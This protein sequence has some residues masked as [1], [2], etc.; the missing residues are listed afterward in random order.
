MR[1]LLCF[2]L[3]LSFLY[4]PAQ[5]TKLYH[6]VLTKQDGLNFDII[7]SMAFD[8][9]GFLWLGGLNFDTRSIISNTKKRT[10]QRFD[11]QHFESFEVPET[12]SDQQVRK[13]NQIVP[14]ND[15][16]FYVLGDNLFSVFNPLTQEFKVVSSFP[17]HFSS[18]YHYNE[19]DY[20]LT[21][22]GREIT[23]NILNDVSLQ[24]LFSFTSSE[25][26]FLVEESSKIIFHENGVLI[27]DDNFPLLFFNWDGIL[28]KRYPFQKYESKN[29]E[30][31][32]DFMI[33]EV[34]YKDNKI[35]AFILNNQQLYEIDFNIL[36]V[37]P[38]QIPNT[39]LEETTIYSYKNGQENV[40]LHTS[41][42]DLMFNRLTENGF[43]TTTAR[44]VFSRP[45]AL[46]CTSTDV[47]KDLWVGTNGGELHYFKFPSKKIEVYMPETEMRT[48]VPL[49]GSTYLVCSEKEGWYV[50]DEITK[51]IVPYEVS[52]NGKK[53]KPNSTR[54]VLVE[55]DILWFNENGF[56]KMNRETRKSNYIKHFPVMCFEPLNEDVIIYGT[57]GY[58]LMSFNKRTLQHDSIA[59][60]D[61]LAIYDL[62]IH[63]NIVVGA[64]SKGILTY[65]VQDKKATMYADENVL[66]DPFLLMADYQEPYGFVLGSRDGT[67]VSYN[68]TTSKYSTLY[69]DDLGAGIAKIVY[70]GPN[71]WISTFNGL[72]H[73]NIETKS[74]QRF[75]EKDGLSD[76]EGNRY[77]GL[78]TKE[79][80]LIGSIKGLNYF[81]PKDLKS[82]AID[83]QLRL[84]ECKKYDL[85][86]NKITS[87]FNQELLGQN[88]VI[89]LPAEHKELELSFALTNNVGFNENSYSYRLNKNEWVALGKEQSIR[90]VNMASGHYNLEIAAHD[91]TGN[92]IGESLKI[93][94]NSKA[95]F[96][97]TWWFYLLISIAVISLLLY[98]L[99]EAQKR[100]KMQ[101]KFSRDLM[102]SQEEERNRIAKELHDSVGQQL[103]LIKRKSQQQEQEELA[104]LTNTVLEEVRS[105][106][107]GLYPANLKLL[108]LTE[109]IQQLA[110][111]MDEQTELFFSLELTNIDAYFD[112]DATLHLYRFVQEALSNILKHANAKEVFIDLT[113]V[114]NIILLT[115]EDNG[116]GFTFDEQQL[117]NSLGLKT[118]A[119]RIKLVKGT[120]TITSSVNHGTKLTAELPTKA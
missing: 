56:Y 51:E 39:F 34:F 40:V 54:N 86:L 38:T 101:V 61:T 25:N 99:H 13:I 36:E 59:K 78:K 69:K 85:A 60:T 11:G 108:G 77:S 41:G 62:A 19:K 48:I 29:H 118:L 21:Q 53:I 102:G 71:W 96:Y 72:V 10:L 67:I 45:Y 22:V 18:I 64:T 81:R 113:K 23:L 95:F 16:F 28:L 90:F 97:K 82:D 98:F 43:A 24:P 104:S 27:S 89:E 84:L 32:E 52:F 49:E 5:E 83:S 57:S 70:D 66:E 79:G 87:V 47:S 80:V 100:Q 55:K 120:L 68:E 75:S 1:F 112:E 115:I 37:R 106:S 3:V 2:L 58:H 12:K 4:V 31:S 20:I 116:K 26:A 9:D 91:F 44:G 46:K 105:I 17:Q 76:N 7:S 8:A 73:Y 117:K 63:N 30:R 119:E 33:D 92:A 111:E 6:K 50:F 107:R 42:Q 14:R 15:G 110:Y 88:A 35:Y 109:S 74:I 114:N 93:Q 94:I 65:N 103:T